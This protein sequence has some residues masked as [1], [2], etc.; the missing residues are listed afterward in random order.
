[1]SRLNRA[2]RAQVIAALIG[3]ASVNATVRMTGVTKRT[4][5]NPFRDMAR[6][7]AEYYQRHVRNLGVRRS[8][9]DEIWAFIEAQKKNASPER[10]A[11]GW[12][13]PDPKYVSTPYVERQNLTMR[14]RM[15]RIRRLTNGYSKKPE[16]HGHAVASHLMH[17][18]C[19]V[20]KT[21]RVTPAMEAGIADHVWTIEE[22]ILRLLPA[23]AIKEAA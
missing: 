16:N 6:A 22:L 9:R 2:K 18:F 14:M 12:G 23:S 1:M 8:Q 11:D 10:K 7:C 3:G 13:D 15:R 19:R 20:H 21:L 17:N 4:V 5:L